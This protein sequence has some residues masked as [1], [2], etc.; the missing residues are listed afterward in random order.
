VGTWAYD[1]MHPEDIWVETATRVIIE[2]G[3]TVEILCSTRPIES[4]QTIERI[5]E[6]P[7]AHAMTSALASFGKEVGLQLVAEGIETEEELETLT[8]AGFRYG[9]GFCFGVPASLDEVL[10]RLS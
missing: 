2:E 7:L 1:Y 10:E 6:N 4:R 9:Q 3:E 5:D 8:D